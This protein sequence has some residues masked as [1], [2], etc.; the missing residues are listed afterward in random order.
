MTDMS[1]E[2][3]RKYESAMHDETNRLVRSAAESAATASGSNDDETRSNTAGDSAA[4]VSG[5]NDD[6][7]PTT[8]SNTPTEKTATFQF[9]DGMSTPSHQHET[10]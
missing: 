5:S 4:A 2:D 3:L 9:P 8:P 1:M 7:S 6:E 10:E